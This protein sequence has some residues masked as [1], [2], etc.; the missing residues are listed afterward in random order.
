MKVIY[1]ELKECDKKCLYYNY[2]QDIS[3]SND[4]GT[5]WCTKNKKP[6]RFEDRYEGKFPDG[7]KLNFPKWCP[8]RDKDDFRK[9]IKFFS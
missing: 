8:L 6:I 5:E 4:D 9:N 2:E 7:K 3:C 1:V